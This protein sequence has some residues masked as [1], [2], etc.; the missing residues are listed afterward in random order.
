MKSRGVKG[1]RNELGRKNP[2][3]NRSHSV[4]AAAVGLLVEHFH[5]PQN[6][7]S[8]GIGVASGVGV[9]LSLAPKGTKCS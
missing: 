6:F 5:L 3:R 2:L 4:I 7:S 9:A 8:A 1:V